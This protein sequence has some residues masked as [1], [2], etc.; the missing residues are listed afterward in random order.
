AVNENGL[1]MAGLLFPKSAFYPPPSQ[2]GQPLAP[3]E[4]IPYLLG[5]CASVWEARELLG[6]LTLA[7]LPFSD[8]LPLSPLHW[9][10]TDG[11]ECLVI[12]ST[13]AGLKLYDDPAGVLTN[14]PP[15]PGQLAHLSAYLHLTAGP[16]EDRLFGG[17][18]GLTPISRGMGAIGLPGDFSSPSRFV[19]AAFLRETSA[20]TCGQAESIAQFFRIMAGVSLP[21]GCVREAD[22]SAV[23]TQYTCCM[24]LSRSSYTFS[25]YADPAL[26]TVSLTSADPEGDS[27][28]RLPVTCG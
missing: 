17:R 28:L 14:E 23:Y 15:F 25:T 7:A 19:R 8:A 24:D 6:G 16:P 13:G 1:A 27:L 11:R 20:P 18:L 10:M 2:G 5:Q 12:E 22:G 26:R 9:M 4:L 3:Y 21:K